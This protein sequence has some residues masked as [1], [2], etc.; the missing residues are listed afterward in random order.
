MCHTDVNCNPRPPQK[1]MVSFMYWLLPKWKKLWFLLFY[2]PVDFLVVNSLIKNLS[3]Q[4]VKKIRKISVE[5]KQ[6]QEPWIILW[7]CS[8]HWSSL[9][10][11]WTNLWLVWWGDFQTN[12]R[13]PRC[14]WGIADMLFSWR[15]RK[16]FVPW[17]WNIF[18]KDYGCSPQLIESSNLN[19]GLH[20]RKPYHWCCYATAGRW[21]LALF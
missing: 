9:L 6:K 10:G 5:R 15:R 8:L 18:R 1:N 4:L 13:S 20:C 21:L 16:R 12:E 3:K 7:P 17:Y 2:S 14:Y 11:M 19:Q